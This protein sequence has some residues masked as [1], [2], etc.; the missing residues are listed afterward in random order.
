VRARGSPGLGRIYAEKFRNNKC[1]SLRYLDGCQRQ[2]SSLKKYVRYH[3]VG[4]VEEGC[5]P[6]LDPPPLILGK[7]TVR[8]RIAIEHEASVACTN[9][10]LRDRH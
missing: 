1:A 6:F 7:N 8:N 4:F 3:I 10:Y 5:Q 2:I 9:V